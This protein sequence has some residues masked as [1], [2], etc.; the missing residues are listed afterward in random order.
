MR[1]SIVP[2][3][4]TEIEIKLSR[5]EARELH[6]DLYRLTQQDHPALGISSRLV[7][8]LTAAHVQHPEE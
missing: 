5:I 7:D 8:L 3:T 4:K 2:S 6:N 1:V